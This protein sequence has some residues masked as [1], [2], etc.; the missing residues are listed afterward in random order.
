MEKKITKEQI[1]LSI[2]NA[3]TYKY[4]LINQK[5]KSQLLKHHITG[6]FNRRYLLIYGDNLLKRY[7]TLYIVDI[8]NLR[9]YNEIFGYEIVDQ[10]LKAVAQKNKDFLRKR[11]SIRKP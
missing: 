6:L 3:A 5:L 4:K 9:T 10:F 8:R 2:I 11:M 7:N 1:L